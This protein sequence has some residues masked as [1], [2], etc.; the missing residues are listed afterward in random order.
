MLFRSDTY[1]DKTQNDKNYNVH[2]PQVSG[3]FRY[4]IRAYHIKFVFAHDMGK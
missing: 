1:S 2:I 3:E 4:N